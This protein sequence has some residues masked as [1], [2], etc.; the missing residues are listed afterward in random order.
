PSARAT[1]LPAILLAALGSAASLSAQITVT[2]TVTTPWTTSVA[3]GPQTDQDSTPIAAAVDSSLTTGPASAYAGI[4]F[5]RE[6]HTWG[7]RCGIRQQ[8][9]LDDTGAVSPASAAASSDVLL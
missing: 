8:L 3:L 5:V 6:T 1:A 2:A 4:D 7:C 9:Y